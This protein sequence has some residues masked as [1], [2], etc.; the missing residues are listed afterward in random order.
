MKIIL[1]LFYKKQIVIFVK[2]ENQSFWTKTHV[3]FNWIKCCQNDCII[4]K[5]K[6]ELYFKKNQNI[7]RKNHASNEIQCWNWKRFKFD[8][9]KHIIWMQFYRSI[10][11]LKQYILINKRQI[12]VEFMSLKHA[13][14]N[15]K[16]KF[17]T[18]KKLI[19]SIE[20]IK[21]TEL[22]MLI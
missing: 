15:L 7:I 9:K 20:S 3:K 2:R 4:H 12:F 16:F 21:L 11:S 13:C 8:D 18:L 10:K 6:S 17:V 22:N 5:D 19:K 1:L 14:V